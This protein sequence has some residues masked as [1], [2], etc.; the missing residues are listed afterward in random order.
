MSDLETR[1][2]KRAWQGLD[3]TIDAVSGH[4]VLDLEAADEIKR[5]H[6]NAAQHHHV[7]EAKE[8][9][10]IAL[11]ASERECER[12]RAVVD[13][14]RALDDDAALQSVAGWYDS[15]K[16]LRDALTRLDQAKETKTCARD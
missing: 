13:A 15:L 3:P 4:G 10:E 1:L 2:R 7:W 11:A 12:L 5:L 8:R 9:A 6:H 14:A 16:H